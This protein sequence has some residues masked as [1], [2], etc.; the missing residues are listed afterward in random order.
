VE[1]YLPG[2][3]LTAG[4]IGTGPDARALGVLEVLFLNRAEA[5]GYSYLNKKD[6]G[7]AGSTS[8]FQT[9]PPPRTRPRWRSRSTGA[10][11]AA[12]P[13][14]STADATRM[15]GFIEINP[16]AGL[17]PYSDLVIL[18]ERSG[19]THSQLVEQILASAVARGRLASR[20]L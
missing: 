5:H 20:L 19:V 14:A 9:M 7:W 12:T 17:A 18:A 6:C 15:V 3:E 11:A 4:I 1:Q 13:R 16:L 10:S 2:R 8:A